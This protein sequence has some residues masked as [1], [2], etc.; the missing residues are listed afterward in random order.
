MRKHHTVR[1]LN[2]NR[3]DHAAGLEHR[4]HSTS[5]PPATVV[6][7]LPPVAMPTRLPVNVGKRPRGQVVK[8]GSKVTPRNRSKAGNA[9]TLRHP[10]IP[11]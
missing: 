2:L 6:H 10:S 9:P 7:K 5:T 4:V 8:G 3:Y 11:R 1:M